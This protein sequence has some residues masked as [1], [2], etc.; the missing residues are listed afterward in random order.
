MPVLKVQCSS[1]FLN[2]RVDI[3]VD[4]AGPEIKNY[5]HNGLICVEYIK[6][7][8]TIFNTFLKPLAFVLK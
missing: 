4:L 5:K 6:K 2:K 8:L 1:K 7:Y 3:T